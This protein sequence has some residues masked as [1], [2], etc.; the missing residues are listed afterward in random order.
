M[1]SGNGYRR[2]REK[3]YDEKQIHSSEHTSERM[4]RSNGRII[5]VSE[6]APE[7]L[8]ALISALSKEHTS[9]SGFFSKFWLTNDE[10][11]SPEWE[12]VLVAI[13]KFERKKLRDRKREVPENSGEDDGIS[14]RKRED[15]EAK[16]IAIE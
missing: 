14:T 2:P 13:G 15:I 9:F 8:N 5:A 1:N 16:W 11:D 3:G 4:L 6:K 7:V 10:V 12:R